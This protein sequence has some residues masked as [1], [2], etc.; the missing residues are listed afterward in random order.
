MEELKKKTEYCILK[1]ATLDR[2]LVVAMHQSKD[3]LRN[4]WMN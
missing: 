1:N 2:T 3:R 4:E